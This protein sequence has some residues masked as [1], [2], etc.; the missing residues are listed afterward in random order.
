MRRKVIQH[1]PTSLAITLPAEWAKKNRIIKGAEVD[2]LEQGNKLTVTNS[3]QKKSLKEIEIDVSNLDRTSIMLSLR[4][5]YRAGY[6]KIHVVYT[7]AAFIHHKTGNIVHVSEMIHSK[8][9][10]LMGFEIIRE[11]MNSC[12]I[13]NISEGLSEEIPTVIKRIHLSLIDIAENIFQAAKNKELENLKNMGDKIDTIIRFINYCL[14]TANKEQDEKT[15][16]FVEYHSLATLDRI[17]YN[18]DSSAKQLFRLKKD[19]NHKTLQTIQITL[20]ALK[21]FNKFYNTKNSSLI[22][23]LNNKRYE[24]AKVIESK[25]REFPKE[26]KIVLF[27]MMQT[28][29]LLVDIAEVRG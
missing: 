1:S 29:H 21:I 4:N 25:F 10:K 27:N 13:A 9:R 20:E 24:L 22:V 5:L 6:D 12:T 7:R 28:H 14:R 3:E 17:V 15:L 2:V 18:L 16:S 8:L 11:Q 19:V 26:E 23:E